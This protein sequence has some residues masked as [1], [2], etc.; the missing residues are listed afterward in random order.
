MQTF[1][2]STV[3]LIKWKKKTLIQMTRN[4]KCWWYLSETSSS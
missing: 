4:C 3:E 1:P 2:P